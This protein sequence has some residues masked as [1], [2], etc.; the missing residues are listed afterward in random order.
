M[1]NKGIKAVKSEYERLKNHVDYYFIDE[2]LFNEVANELITLFLII[3]QQ[4]CWLPILDSFLTYSFLLIHFEYLYRDLQSKYFYSYL[5]ASTGFL[6]A[7]LQ[8]CQLTVN[9][10]TPRAKTPAKTK[11]HQL[12]VVL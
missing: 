1:I 6:V 4:Y 5:K 10:A 12:N 7:A 3:Y 8:L 2:I 11:I 9:I